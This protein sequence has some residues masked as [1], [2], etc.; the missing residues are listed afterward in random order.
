MRRAPRYLATVLVL[1]GALQGGLAGTAHAEEVCL[2]LDVSSIPPGDDVTL[3]VYVGDHGGAGDPEVGAYMVDH[4]DFPLSGNVIL[5]ED[6]QGFPM[7]HGGVWL[8]N[9]ETWV[10]YQVSRGSRVGTQIEVCVSVDGGEP[11][12]VLP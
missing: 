5:D 7:V 2:P 9:G 3:C 1:A 12:C 6:G 10:I 11:V 8:D 4:E